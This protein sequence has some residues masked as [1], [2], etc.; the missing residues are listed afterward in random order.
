MFKAG[1]DINCGSYIPPHLMKALADGAVTRSDMDVALTHL[2]DVL[3]RLGLFETEVAQPL[4]YAGVASV[5]SPAHRQITLEAAVQGCVL[6]TNNNHTLPLSRAQRPLASVAVVGQEECKLGPYAATPR[7]E[8]RSQHCTIIDGLRRVGVTEL[9]AVSELSA[10]CDQANSQVVVAVLDTN[11]Q[12]ESHDRQSIGPA[13]V[14]ARALA[15]IE[16]QR[17]NGTC[18]NG[19]PFVLVVQGACATDLSVAASAFDAVL[20]AGAGGER[21]GEAVGRVLYG[22]DAPSGRLPITLYGCVAM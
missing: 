22:F 10:A 17:N 16:D 12:G 5:G 2:F 15:S 9:T 13:D 1:L 11:C 3:M 21:A 19:K 8:D 6:L 4:R 20:W 14:D 18:H 7:P